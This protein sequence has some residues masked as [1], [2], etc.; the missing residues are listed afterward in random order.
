MRRT[1]RINVPVSLDDEECMQLKRTFNCS[2]DEEF[3]LHLERIAQAAVSEYLEMILG[4]QLP[5]RADEMHARRLFHL[6]K[7]YY[8]DG[9]PSEAEVAAL[10][11]ETLSRSRSL[12]RNVRAKYRYE[13]EDEIY[14]TVR[15]TLADAKQDKGGSY[16]V[17]IQCDN[18]LEELQQTVSRLA[19]HLDQ[20]SKVRNSANIYS[21]PEDTFDILSRHFGV[22]LG[23]D[24]VA[25]SSE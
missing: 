5:T 12:L 13:L 11:Q 19:P 2:S 14:N 6:L 7:F 17:V 20:I 15:D 24:D 18:I 22:A 21:I 16:R 10:F 8:T 1:I 3:M 4:Q 9:I 25:I 23:E